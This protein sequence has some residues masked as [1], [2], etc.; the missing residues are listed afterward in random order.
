MNRYSKIKAESPEGDPITEADRLNAKTIQVKKAVLT[1]DIHRYLM[2]KDKLLPL[3]ASLDPS[4]LKAHRA[5]E[6]FPQFN[7]DDPQQG[8][9]IEA[10]L[11]SIIDD[12]ISANLLDATD[13]AVI[14]S[15]MT[16]MKS[17][18]EV[19]GMPEIKPAEII[20]A[21]ENY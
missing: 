7:I 4:A 8:A 3:E 9:I 6:I 20:F 13:K 11:T 2:L 19:N 15:F 10:K 1:S 5:F 21:R 18:A 17:W 16:E 14:Q 12:L